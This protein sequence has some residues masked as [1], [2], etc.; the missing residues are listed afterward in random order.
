MTS[1]YRRPCW[2]YKQVPSDLPAVRRTT[3]RKNREVLH[4]NPVDIGKI[5]IQIDQIEQIGARLL[6]I[7]KHSDSP[8]LTSVAKIKGEST[9]PSKLFSEVIQGKVKALSWKEYFKDQM[10]SEKLDEEKALKFLHEKF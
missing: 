1:I 4:L 2:Q 10:N 6:V 9:K 5:E 3:A 7:N 8:P